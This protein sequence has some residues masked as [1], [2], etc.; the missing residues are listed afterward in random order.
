MTWSSLG[1]ESARELVDLG[2]GRG[3]QLEGAV[4]MHNIL[5]RERVAYLADE[6]GLGKTYVA[7][8]TMA[9]FRH[10]DPGFRVLVL[11]PRRNIQH[12][13]AKDWRSFVRHNWKATDLRV[14]AASG[15]PT[16]PVRLP[17]RLSDLVQDSV[18]QP[19]DDHMARLSSF[20]S[21][22]SPGSLSNQRHASPAFDSS[23]SRAV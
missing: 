4:A 14:R 5:Q 9:L 20:S 11:A 13:W 1:L 6:V 22:R 2:D 7:L 3:A 15:A 21:S 18:V 12:K 17:E 23:S 8:T 19:R 10:F 16:H